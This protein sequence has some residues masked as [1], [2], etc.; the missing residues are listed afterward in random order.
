MN[1]LAEFEKRYKGNPGQTEDI[2]K[3]IAKAFGLDPEDVLDYV[4]IHRYED[5]ES[6]DEKD[7]R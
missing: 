7:E 5:N 1:I 2:C 6:L 4:Y 3:E